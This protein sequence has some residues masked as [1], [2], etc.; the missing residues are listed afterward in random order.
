MVT[1]VPGSSQDRPDDLAGRDFRALAPN[2]LRVADFT[3]IGTGAGTACT[4]LVID[5][6]SR[7][8]AGW[9]TAGHHRLTLVLDALVMAV[10]ARRRQ[11]VTVAGAIHHCDA[12]SE[13][14]AIRYGRELTAAGMT[15]SVGSVGDSYDNALAESMIGLYK[16]EVIARQG[17]WRD[18]ARVET[19]TATWAGWFNQQRL[20][21]PIGRR[22]P[23]EYEQ[24]CYAGELDPAALTSGSKT[25]GKSARKTRKTT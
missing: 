17:P 5:A 3:Y 1:T 10:A 6:F 2:R 16:T 19:A 15:P 4:A 11:G 7:M 23:A 12:G 13:Y 22:P 18:L 20:F 21:W 24:A 14:L 9:R 25:P 8:I